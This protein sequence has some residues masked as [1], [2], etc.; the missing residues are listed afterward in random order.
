[1]KKTKAFWWTIGLI[2]LALCVFGQITVGGMYIIT[3]FAYL[4]LIA[5]IAN[6]I[7]DC[8]LGLPPANI[9]RD[10]CFTG[11]TVALIIILFCS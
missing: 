4:I 2:S 3:Q 10:A 11:I 5:N 6:I 1:M 9:V 8:V 7:R